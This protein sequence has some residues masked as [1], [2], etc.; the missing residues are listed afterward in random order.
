[1]VKMFLYLDGDSFIKYRCEIGSWLF[2]NKLA[3]QIEI[4]QRL[5]RVKVLFE[6][7]SDAL[8]FAQYFEGL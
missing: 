2:T 8:K 5:N 6:N 3:V 1:M 7:T 4:H